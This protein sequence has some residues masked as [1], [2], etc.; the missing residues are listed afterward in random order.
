MAPVIT[1]HPSNRLVETLSN[2]TLYCTTLAKPQASIEWI[3][4]GKTLTNMSDDCNITKIRVT[5]STKGSCMITDPLSECESSSTLEILN[6]K[7]DD[8]GNYICNVSNEAGYVETNA[9]LSVDGMCILMC[10][11]VC[12][13]F[14]NIS[15][16]T[17][18]YT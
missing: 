2:V 12:L 11:N 14:Y 18:I 7:P 4:N 8:S 16:H 9:H 10:L 1:T 15:I 5:R 13:Q 3:N 6:T 17:C